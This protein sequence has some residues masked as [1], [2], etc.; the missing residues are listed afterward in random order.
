LE[1]RG[2]LMRERKGANERPN[3]GAGAPHTHETKKE[4]VQKE[5]GWWCTSAASEESHIGATFR[6]GERAVSIKILCEHTGRSSTSEAA[7]LIWEASFPG[8]AYVDEC[9]EHNSGIEVVDWNVRKLS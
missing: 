4:N 9:F 8:I 7:N 2:S 3:D 1:I 5:E 6:V